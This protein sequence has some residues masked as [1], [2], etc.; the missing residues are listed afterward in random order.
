MLSP[1]IFLISVARALIE[2]AGYALM[3][4]GVLAVL[5]GKSRDQNA[6]YRLLQSVTTPAVKAVR[7]LTPRVVIDRHI[8][9]VT[10]FILFWLWIG[11]ALAKRHICAAQGLSCMT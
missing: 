5:A 6:V 4:Q 8:P 9:V 2:V 1:E 7:F 10:F 3:G 11:L